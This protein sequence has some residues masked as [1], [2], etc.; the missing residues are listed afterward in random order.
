[1]ILD[2][3]DPPERWRALGHGYRVEARITVRRGEDVLLVPLSA[4]FRGGDDWAVFVAQD[5]RA[6]LRTVRIG[7]RDGRV[8]EVLAGLE[9]GERVVLHP[10]DRVADGVRLAQRTEAT[11]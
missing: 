9:A 3:T 7:H 11:R 2:F 5:G 10:S 6:A 1:V 8:A 4:L